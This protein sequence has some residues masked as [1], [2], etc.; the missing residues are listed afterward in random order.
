MSLCNNAMLTTSAKLKPCHTNT[1]KSSKWFLTFL[2]VELNEWE[3][4]EKMSFTDD[5]QQTVEGQ[6]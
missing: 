2:M 5:A 6:N 4:E 3:I 1:F